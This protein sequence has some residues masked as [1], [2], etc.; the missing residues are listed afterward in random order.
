MRSNLRQVRDSYRWCLDRVPLTEAYGRARAGNAV[1]PIGAR[2][3]GPRPPE[4]TDAVSHRPGGH[5]ESPGDGPSR[6]GP[7]GKESRDRRVGVVDGRLSH[8]RS[9]RIAGARQGDGRGLP[10]RCRGDGLL[11]AGTRGRRQ[12]RPEPGAIGPGRFRGLSPEGGQIRAPCRAARCIPSRTRSRMSSRSISATAASIV[13]TNRPA[14]EF[15][16]SSGCVSA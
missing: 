15:V 6:Q 12:G 16:S 10:S 8:V 4:L 5:S 11:A 13:K 7:G 3:D 1:K 2:S 14:A 9:P